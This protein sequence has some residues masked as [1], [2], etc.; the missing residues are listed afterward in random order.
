MKMQGWQDRQELHELPHPVLNRY[1]TMA[2]IRYD[3][4]IEEDVNGNGVILLAE[5]GAVHG[6]GNGQLHLLCNPKAVMPLLDV[7]AV[8]FFLFPG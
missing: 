1:Q 2:A 6:I 3:V 7:F 5:K 4:P 8:Q